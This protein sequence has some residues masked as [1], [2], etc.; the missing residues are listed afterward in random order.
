VAE[1]ASDHLVTL[2]LFPGLSD[3]DVS[4]VLAA[5][6]KVVGHFLP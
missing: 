3:D 1:D 2:P 4:D 5:V 6:E